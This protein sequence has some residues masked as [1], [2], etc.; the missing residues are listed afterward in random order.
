MDNWYIQE[1]MNSFVNSHTELKGKPER[2]VLS[3]MVDGGVIS[4]AEYEQA[5]QNSTF[6]TGFSLANDNMGLSVEHSVEADI[7]NSNLDVTDEYVFKYDNERIKSRKSR[8]NKEET[9]YT[10]LKNEEG[11]AYVVLETR[12]SDGTKI[13]STALNVNPETGDVEDSDFISKTITKPDGT[14]IYVSTEP[15]LNGAIQEVIIKDDKITTNF[16]NTASISEYDNQEV[17]KLYQRIETPDKVYEIRYDGEGN[18]YVVLQNGDSFERLKD[19]FHVP[20]KE[21]DNLNDKNFDYNKMQVGGIV[22]VPGEIAADDI[23]VRDRKSSVEAK[24]AFFNWSVKHERDNLFACSLSEYTIKK[25]HT[26]VESLAKEILPNGSKEQIRTLALRIQMLNPDIINN[27]KPNQKIKI[28]I[29]GDNNARDIAKSAGFV[30]TQANNAFYQILNGLSKEDRA[31]VIEEIQA[32]KKQ[33]ITNLTE[34]KKRVFEKTG[35]SVFDSGKTVMNN[36]KK[37]PVEFIAETYGMDMHMPMFGYVITKRFPYLPQDYLDKID[38]GKVYNELKK[39][40]DPNNITLDQVF[41]AFEEQGCPLLSEDEVKFGYFEGFSSDGEQ[42]NSSLADI[43][44]FRLRKDTLACL[45]CIYESGMSNLTDYRDNQGLFGQLSEGLCKAFNN[46]S[47]IESYITQLQ[48]DKDAVSGYFDSIKVYSNCPEQFNDIFKQMTGLDYNQS[49]DNIQSFLTLATSG[50]DPKSKEYQDAFKKA[51]GSKLF[52]EISTYC[53]QKSFFINLANLSTQ[54]CLMLSPVGRGLTGFVSKGLGGS[55]GATAVANGVTMGLTTAAV[56]GIDLVVKDASISSQDISNYAQSVMVS[57]G[58][59]VFAGGMSPVFSKVC[60]SVS[61]GAARICPKL[62]KAPNVSKLESVTKAL[63][64]GKTVSGTELMST[65]LSKSGANFVGKGIEF[66]TEIIAF[67]LYSISTGPIAAK[68]AEKLAASLFNKDGTLKSEYDDEKSLGEKIMTELGNQFQGLLTCQGLTKIIM[69]FCSKKNVNAVTTQERLSGFETLKNVEFKYTKINGKDVIVAKTPRGN[70]KI[71]SV[72]DAVKF[73]EVGMSVEAATIVNA[74]KFESVRAELES[75]NS[76]KETTD[77][78]G[79]KILIVHRNIANLGDYTFYKFDKNGNFVETGSVKKSN[80]KQ[81]FGKSIDEFSRLKTQE[82]VNVYSFVEPFSPAVIATWRGVI[83]PLFKSAKINV[84]HAKFKNVTDTMTK[85]AMGLGIDVNN[86][87]ELNEFRA[88]I[89]DIKVEGKSPDQLVSELRDLNLVQPDFI[90]NLKETSPNFESELNYMMRK[91]NISV[92]EFNEY[93]SDKRFERFSA[94]DV[95][96]EVYKINETLKL[97]GRFE[98]FNL[99]FAEKAKI[100]KA[101]KSCDANAIG[102]VLLDRNFELADRN[103]NMESLWSQNNIAILRSK[104]EKLSYN[105]T[106]SGYTEYNI[107]GQITRVYGAGKGSYNKKVEGNTFETVLKSNMVTKEAVE[108]ILNDVDSFPTIKNM[109]DLEVSNLKVGTAE[110]QVLSEGIKYIKPDGTAY[111]YRDLLQKAKTDFGSLNTQE[112]HK[113]TELLSKTLSITEIGLLSKNSA[114]QAQAKQAMSLVQQMRNSTTNKQCKVDD[115]FYMR[116]I[117]RNMTSGFITNGNEIIPAD[118]NTIINSVYEKAV[119]T[120]KTGQFEVNIIIN[121]KNVKCK[122]ENN[123]GK[124]TLVTIVG[125]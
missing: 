75:S 85:L 105:S 41:M 16:Y 25:K 117:D 8:D 31:K 23:S 110:G 122:V 107:N 91:Y 123:K 44:E 70:I 4:R 118:M 100:Y 61:S 68:L 90:K 119:A 5:C 62:F 7:V 34:I 77:A 76:A 2:V 78:N 57:T 121:N 81:Q 11:I 29:E 64:S 1:K 40:G 36:G 59:G 73:C 13:T 79:N 26:S 63:E 46:G 14:K 67:S 27:L 20:R 124:I 93:F 3:A 101:L 84:Q 99:S 120:N 28:A 60:S 12:L 104:S 56:E 96:T 15:S 125:D 113:I 43:S 48:N 51:F 88:K 87:K 95:L 106:I 22:R 35:I 6:G 52:D 47:S 37:V 49:K 98:L 21:L 50:S 53:E 45:L 38:L 10:Y 9:I 82:S 32:C 97:D 17:H 94:N 103:V 108:A 69:A 80:L 58:F 39:L 42:F 115:H 71:N 18:S 83:D 74:P 54:V 102:D 66:A 86:P 111:T 55:L 65:Y 112:I 116:M 92:S 72:A 89:K 24:Q 30:P 109:L 114:V 19:N 33:N